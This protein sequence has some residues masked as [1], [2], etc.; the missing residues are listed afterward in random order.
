MVHCDIAWN[1]STSSSSVTGQDNGTIHVAMMDNGS[2]VKVGIIGQDNT[3]TVIGGILAGT[4]SGV[5]T[6]V[7]I[8]V[9]SGDNKSVLAV[10]KG[11]SYYLLKQDAVGT[12][13]DTIVAGTAAGGT[14]G[15]LSLNVSPDG[16]VYAVA[17]DGSNDNTSIRVFYDE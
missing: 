11:G 4:G 12:A 1:F 15:K 9:D 13:F 5:I 16:A 6:D 14:S 2:S 17:V 7:E 8:A 10:L 3:S